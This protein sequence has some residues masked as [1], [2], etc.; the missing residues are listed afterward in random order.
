MQ[1][2]LR[3]F[4]ERAVE[5]F[6]L[7]GPVYDFV[8]CGGVRPAVAPWRPLFLG[9]HYVN[10]GTRLGPGIDRLF[11][12]A[13]LAMCDGAAR[14]VIGIGLL[15]RV[16]EPLRAVEELTRVL[17]PGGVMLLAAA[18]GGCLD[19]PGDYWRMTPSCLARMLAPL[20]AALVAWQ[21]AE[22]SPHTVFGIGCKAPIAAGVSGSMK[23]L[24]EGYQ[25]WV[26]AAGRATPWPQKLKAAA[27]RWCTDAR[28]PHAGHDFQQVRFALDLPFDRNWKTDLLPANGNVTTPVRLDLG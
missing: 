17:A 3:A 19:E 18:W 20:D 11:D 5:A 13:R 26:A 10:C 27:A 24:I 6:E 4:V 12:P 21:G 28:W 2:H 25:Q 7:R 22:R 15:E 8:A 23:R 1:N 9:Q 14:T 16:F